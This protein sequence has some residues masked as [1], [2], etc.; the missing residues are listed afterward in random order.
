MNKSK[1]SK[2]SKPNN[3]SGFTLIELLV[4]I[5]IIAL[6]SSV[7]LASLSKSREKAFI[8]S[9]RQ[10]GI[11]L[12]NALE[13][14]YL[15][16]REYPSNDVQYLSNPL[17]TSLSYSLQSKLSKEI[18]K[19]MP[20]LQKGVSGVTFYPAWAGHGNM[21]YF[22]NRTYLQDSVWVTQYHCEGTTIA[23]PYKV[24]FA[25]SSADKSKFDGSF[26]KVLSQSNSHVRSLVSGIYYYYYC[27]NTPPK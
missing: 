7:V 5:A 23:S 19:I 10:E 18:S 17:N 14:Y 25:V 26:P 2:F 20:T 24:V 1:F 21:L 15:K 6:L 8:S 16:N 4:V 9:I 11:Q 12:G 3:F 22:N 27:V 13:L